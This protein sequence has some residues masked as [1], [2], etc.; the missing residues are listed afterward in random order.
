MS[1]SVDQL[2]AQP[3]T[4]ELGGRTLK[5]SPL[6]IDDFGALQA[7]IY[8]QLPDPITS[9][10]RMA[11]GLPPTALGELFREA[12]REE[13]AS[14]L[15]HRIGTAGAGEMLQGLLGVVELLYLTARRHHPDLTRDELPA[16]ILSAGADG[17]DRVSAHAFGVEA[18]EGDADP[19]AGGVPAP[20]SST[21]SP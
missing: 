7:W 10:R 17:I 14:R 16:L 13:R 1:M 11:E 4:I 12:A 5:I 9:A 15:A 6:T 21:S 19:K 18:G 20:S 2:T 3:R 8:S